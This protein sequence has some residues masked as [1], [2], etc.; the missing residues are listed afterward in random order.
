MASK[1]VSPDE[2]EAASQPISPSKEGVACV[3]KGGVALVPIKGGVN[4]VSTKGRGLCGNKGAVSL[5][6]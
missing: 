2:G 3:D 6:Q 1:P 4:S 5:N